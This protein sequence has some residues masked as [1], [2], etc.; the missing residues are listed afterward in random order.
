MAGDIGVLCAAI[1]AYYYFRVIIASVFQDP[2][3]PE[4]LPITGGFEAALLLAAAIVITLGIFP[5]LLL[6]FL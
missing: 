1:S 2:A 5:G 3:T 6:Q 4:T